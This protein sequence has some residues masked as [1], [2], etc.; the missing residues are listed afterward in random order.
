MASTSTTTDSERLYR[1]RQILS[2]QL[3]AVLFWNA[4]RHEDVPLG[5]MPREEF[6]ELRALMFDE[7]PTSQPVTRGG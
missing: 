2:I 1:I 4:E 6:M 7:P 5:T 3:Q